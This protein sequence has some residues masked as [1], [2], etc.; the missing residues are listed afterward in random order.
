M[1][2]RRRRAYGAVGDDRADHGDHDP[3]VVYR[4]DLERDRGVVDHG[5]VD[6][7]ALDHG[8]GGQF[9]VSFGNRQRDLRRDLSQRG[10]Q[11]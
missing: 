7:A 1:R 4:G 9:A 3:R 11:R 8:V 2:W 10:H 6:C 5:D